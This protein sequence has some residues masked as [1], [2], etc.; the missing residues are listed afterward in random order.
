MLSNKEKSRQKIKKGMQ[1][2][3]DI[4]VGEEPE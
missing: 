4:Y 3:Y 1:G 2:L